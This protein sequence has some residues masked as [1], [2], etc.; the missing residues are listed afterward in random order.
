MRRAA[1]MVVSV[2][3]TASFPNPEIVPA[4]FAAYALLISTALPVIV[5]GK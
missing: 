2:M 1:S 4:A 5:K 3:V